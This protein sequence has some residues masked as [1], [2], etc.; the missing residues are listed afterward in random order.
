MLSDYGRPARLVPALLVLVVGSCAEAAPDALL[1]DS[2]ALE[3]PMPARSTVSRAGWGSVTGFRTAETRVQQ[4]IASAARRAHGQSS[5]RSEA[6]G[7]GKI[8]FTDATDVPASKDGTAMRAAY[9]R[10]FAWK[11]RPE[12]LSLAQVRGRMIQD[13]NITVYDASRRSML[14]DRAIA[15]VNE[16][17]RYAGPY[18]P[19]RQEQETLDAYGIRK[20]CIEW[21]ATIAISQGGRMKGYSASAVTDP[22]RFRPGMG[23]YRADKS[24]AMLIVDVYWDTSGRPTRFRV[25]EANWAS[26]WANP[27]GQIPWQRTVAVGREIPYNSSV[28]VI[29]YET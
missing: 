18:L 14:A 17:L 21:A 9:N 4:S 23:L 22:A 7:P 8:W 15:R 29:D 25:A 27:P 16:R 26:G 10:Y 13:F 28:R 1:P 5:G 12:G 2:A 11:Y 20:Q 19:L 6:S 3:A 24:H